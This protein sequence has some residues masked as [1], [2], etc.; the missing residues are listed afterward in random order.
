MIKEW[1]IKEKVEVNE[2][3]HNENGTGKVGGIH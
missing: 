1:R 2:M 3:T